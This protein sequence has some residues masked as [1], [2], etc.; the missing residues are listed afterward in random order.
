ML[1]GS[2]G[3]RKI[4]DSE[5]LFLAL[6]TGMAVSCNN[7]ETGTLLQG[8]K[9][10]VSSE[11]SE[12]AD[13]C[14]ADLSKITIMTGRDCRTSGKVLQDAFIAGALHCGAKV[15]DGGIAPTPTVAYAG[16]KTS[17]SC[18]ITASHNPEEFNGLKLLNPDGSA[19]TKK[20]QVITEKRIAAIDGASDGASAGGEN[21]GNAAWDSQGTL[22]AED[23]ITPHKEK[24]LDSFDI[25][26][27]LRMVVD[28]GCG[29][30][31]VI[32]PGLLADAGVNAAC[33]NCTPSGVFARPSEPLEAN[34]PYIHDFVLKRGANGAIVHDGDADRFMGFDEK[35]RYIS[36][37]HLMMLFA[38]FLGAKHV[39]TTV[40]ASMAIEE[41]AEVHRTPVGDSYVS[42]ELLSWGDFG[43]EASGAWIFPKMSLCPDGIYAAGLFC[44]IAS[45][46]KISELVDRMPSYPVL[47]SSYPC[48]KAK[49]V[50]IAM[51]AENPTDGIRITEDD[52]WCLIRAS[53]TEPKVRITAE[54]R[55]SA[56]A[57]K[58]Q[59]KGLTMLKSAGRTLSR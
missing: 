59:E 43:G 47:R 38:E 21:Y 35:G 52:G 55:T 5:L 44:S 4:Y 18:C 7:P 14:G 29:A 51:G 20:Q 11:L 24:I 39:V 54:G 40:D 8:L 42:E 33:I 32:T 45:E 57:K 28:C 1:F 49:E 30:G 2:S 13:T 16:R 9:S 58:M 10:P 48:G 27:K 50:L 31:S 41:T 19:F 26:E 3:I 12:S 53:G 46:H 36:G 22:S 6:K 25:S 34:L 37:D 17:L 23:I 15:V 56:G